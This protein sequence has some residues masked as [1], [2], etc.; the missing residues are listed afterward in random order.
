MPWRLPPP[1]TPI[2]F[3]DCFSNTGG[4]A[5]MFFRRGPFHI[6]RLGVSRNYIASCIL[7][8]AYLAFFE[9]PDDEDEN[10]DRRLAN[11]WSS[12]L[13]YCVAESRKPQTAR[14]F[15]TA[16]LHATKGSLPWISCKGGD[17]VIFLEWI[18]FFLRLH[19]YQLRDVDP[20]D[21]SCLQ[22]MLSGVEAGLK[23]T[24][25]IYRHGVWLQNSETMCSA[26]QDVLQGVLTCIFHA[27]ARKLQQAVVFVWASPK[28]SCNVP[29]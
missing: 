5:S 1:F 13:L 9:T 26:S 7:M 21:L 17:S 8:L 25:T 6:F 20:G 12:C 19:I 28:V 3:E 15:T 14:K 16:K 18:R 22:T 23:F 29:L 24:K 10:T 2:A 4:R 11:A 27:C